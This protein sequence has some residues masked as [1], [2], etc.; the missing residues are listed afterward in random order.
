M[1]LGTIYGYYKGK[2]EFKE[3]S[4]EQGYGK[5]SVKQKPE[6]TYTSKAREEAQEAREYAGEAVKASGGKKVMKS[7]YK[8]PGFGNLFLETL[9]LQRKWGGLVES[10]Q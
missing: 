3:Y 9:V 5:Y 10:S 2:K 4:K 7:Y 1:V 6:G 8:N